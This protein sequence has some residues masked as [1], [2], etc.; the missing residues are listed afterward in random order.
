MRP[1]GWRP[2]L[3]ATFAIGVSNSVVFSVLSDLQDEFGFGSAGLGFI[4]GAGFVVGFLTQLL[5][6]PYADRGLSKH[7]L[8]GGLVLAVA[9]SVL[10]AAGSSLVVFVLARAVIGLSNGCFLP[11]ARAITASLSPVGVGE[12]LGRLGGIELAGFV[13]GPVVGGVLVDPLGVRWPFL[14][15]GIA[16]AVALVFLAPRP[17]PQPPRVT[18]AIRRLSLDLLRLRGIRVGVLLSVALFLPI[19]VF[20]ALWDRYLTD[21]GASNT[22]VGLSFLMYGI[23]FALLAP[24]G[25]RLADRIGSVR[26][27]LLALV[28]VAPLTA[29][30]GL[31]AAPLLIIGLSMVEGSFQAIGVPGAQATVAAAAPPGRAT[32]AQGLAGSAQ[33]LS[34]AIAAFVSPA[35]YGPLGGTAVFALAGGCVGLFALAA[36]RVSSAAR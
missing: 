9:G 11:A 15:C 17:L 22:V 34:A 21:R 18:G 27:C 10:F 1:P 32:A 20:D 16:A 25:G 6:A 19:G 3:A 24:R 26:A 5:V 31:V 35:L 2:L 33:L 7:L 30:Y 13:T 4:A 28:F 8:L 23:P 29:S 14:V 36:W 12:R